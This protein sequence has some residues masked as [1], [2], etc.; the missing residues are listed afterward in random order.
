[1]KK[2]VISF[3]GNSK[4]IDNYIFCSIKWQ[5][6]YL[7]KYMIQFF[8]VQVLVNQFN[9]PIFQIL[10]ELDKADLLVVNFMKKENKNYC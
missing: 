7:M 6:K 1:M 4:R 5:F 3:D 9:S 2:Q 8:W 10:K